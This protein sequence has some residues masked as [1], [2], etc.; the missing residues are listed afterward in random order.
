MECAEIALY[1]DTIISLIWERPMN[2]KYEMFKENEADTLYRIRALRDFGNVKAGNIGGYIENESSLSHEGDCWVSGNARV[3]GNALVFGNAWVFGNALVYDN[4]RVFGNAKVYGN[5]WIFGNAQISGYARVYE[6]ALVY[7]D[8]RVYENAR[9]YGNARV[10]DNAW[11]SDNARVTGYA[12]VYENSNVAAVADEPAQI[13]KHD[14]LSF[15]VRDGK[16]DVTE[17]VDTLK[18]LKI[19]FKINLQ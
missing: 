8:A 11:V 19:N 5:A 2:K 17:L 13:V 18:K 16:V 1:L 7:G 14:S 10:F 15:N 9:V 6:N 12:R 3:F 4:A